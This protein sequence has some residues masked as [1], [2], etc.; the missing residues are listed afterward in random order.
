MNNLVRRLIAHLPF[1]PY[2]AIIWHN[3]C[4]MLQSLFVGL[5]WAATIAGDMQWF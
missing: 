3:Q 1:A 2:A 4:Q 5:W